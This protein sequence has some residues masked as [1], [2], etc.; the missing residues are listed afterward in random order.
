MESNSNPKLAGVDACGQSVLAKRAW[1]GAAYLGNPW[2]CSAPGS[3]RAVLSGLT[4]YWC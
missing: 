2:C 1:Y 4:A 3:Q